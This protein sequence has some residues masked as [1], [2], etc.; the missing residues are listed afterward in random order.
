M[1]LQRGTPVAGVAPETA[2]NMARA[3][4]DHWRTTTAIADRVRVPAA[5]LTELLEQLTDTGYLQRRDD[6]H[7]ARAEWNTTITGGALTMASFLKAISRARA[8]KLLA[9]VLSARTSTAPTTPSSTS[10][11]SSPCSAPT[12][13]P[14]RP[15]SAA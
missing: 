15:N 9:G 10:S 6:R 14:T 3:C 2:R 1:R 4:H 5:E 7:S 12:C 11:P 13:A 8:E